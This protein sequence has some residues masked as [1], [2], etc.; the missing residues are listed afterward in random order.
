MI[1]V[2]HRTQHR[3]VVI[4]FTDVL[5]CVYKLWAVDLPLS[6]FFCLKVGLWAGPLLQGCITLL[7]HLR[8]LKGV[9]VLGRLARRD[10]L[11]PGLGGR[12]ESLAVSD[13]Y[14]VT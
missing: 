14:P 1:I 6:V 11:A 8:R 3:K 5:C 7:C 10:M 4:Q 12:G 13:F 2:G 9:A